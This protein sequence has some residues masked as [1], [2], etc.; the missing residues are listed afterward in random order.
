LKRRSRKW[1]FGSKAIVRDKRP[2]SRSRCNM[3]GKMAVSFGGAK[4]KP[5]TVQMD[6]SPDRQ[7][8][9]CTQSPGTPPRVSAS[10]VT[11]PRGNTLSMLPG[12]P[13]P[14]ISRSL[15]SQPLLPPSHVADA[16]FVAILD[17]VLTVQERG[18]ARHGQF[19]NRNN[20]KR[21]CVCRGEGRQ[22][23]GC[24]PRPTLGADQW[25]RMEEGCSRNGSSRGAARRRHQGSAR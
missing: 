10:N 22:S 12:A 21:I 8:A 24:R 16:P 7:S 25:H 5:T 6:A 14:V 4:V 1:I 17:P 2:R 13:S 15:S 23:R 20:L 9:G 3:P 18:F 19:N 11:T